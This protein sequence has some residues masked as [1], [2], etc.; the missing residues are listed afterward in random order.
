MA[1]LSRDFLA[2]GSA[3]A[4]RASPLG[5]MELFMYSVDSGRLLFVTV[6]RNVSMAS[7]NSATNHRSPRKNLALANAQAGGKK[8]DV[9]HPGQGTGAPVVQSRSSEST[10]LLNAASPPADRVASIDAP[11]ITTA[12]TA[13]HPTMTTTTTVTSTTTTAPQQ[14]VTLLNS[15]GDF[16]APVWDHYTECATPIHGIRLN[17][18][19]GTELVRQVGRIPCTTNFYPVDDAFIDGFIGVMRRSFASETGIAD[20]EKEQQCWIDY[21]RQLAPAQQEKPSVWIKLFNYALMV[22]KA[23]HKEEAAAGRQDPAGKLVKLRNPIDGIRR[24]LARIHLGDLSGQ[25]TSGLNDAGST[26]SP[27]KATPAPEKHRRASMTALL[28][29]SSSG[30]G[31]KTLSQLPRE[32]IA[33]FDSKEEALLAWKKKADRQF[34]K[35]DVSRSLLQ[36]FERSLGTISTDWL[37]VHCIAYKFVASIVFAEATRGVG[38][39]EALVEATTDELGYVNEILIFRE[40]LK[41]VVRP[42]SG[43]TPQDKR[44][45]QMWL[46]FFG[47]VARMMHFKRDNRDTALSAS[48]DMAE[49]LASCEI[50]Y[51]TLVRAMRQADEFLRQQEGDPRARHKAE[52][53]K[54]RRRKGRSMDFLMPG[55][56]KGPA[57]PSGTRDTDAIGLSP[58][59]M[60]GEKP[61]VKR[62]AGTDGT[63]MREGERIRKNS[64]A[65]ESL[66]D[67][68]LSASD[69][70]TSPIGG[71]KPKKKSATYEATRQ[72][73]GPAR[74]AEKKKAKS[75]S[76]RVDQGGGVDVPESEEND[77][78]RKGGKE[79]REAKEVKTGKPEKTTGK[80]S[81]GTGE[82]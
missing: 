11:S 9:F 66:P 32:E 41:A 2:I 29:F 18:A 49:A 25:D 67:G 61:P 24:N 54:E 62:T 28:P 27:S 44:Y 68:G 72:E 7:K 73:A 82:D 65:A 81:T 40:K 56:S 34:D 20:L 47:Q 69:Q 19:C 30:G 13:S 3:M 8:P 39:G 51:D 5:N 57:Q 79:K 74:V 17:D 60:S 15:D 22:A 70:P 23:L 64:P 45:C 10:S 38:I 14:R 48:P 16:V 46:D 58:E 50:A 63:A 75:R 59:K 1:K 6:K 12:V 26:S 37:A 35:Q 42:D 31:K 55:K 78:P 43:A 52:R 33:G 53:A 36:F 80:A 77:K 71:S 76:T 21:Q 4:Y